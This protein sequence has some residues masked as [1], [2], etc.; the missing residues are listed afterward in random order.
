LTG[1]DARLPAHV[2]VGALLRQV[3][4][5]GGFAT[6]LAKG[7]RDGGTIVVV[8]CHNG[9][10][11]RAYE[12][13]PQADGTRGWACARRQQAEAPWEFTEYLD[14]RKAQDDDLW[15]IELDIAHGERFIGLSDS[16]G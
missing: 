1:L 12:R 9:R 10:D 16:I 15:I 2:E 13:M 11:C 8:V 4:A 6:V 3:E 7:D 14:R 5:A